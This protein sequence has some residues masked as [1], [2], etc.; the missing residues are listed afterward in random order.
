MSETSASDLLRLNI[1]AA[2]PKGWYPTE[3]ERDRSAGAG[4]AQPT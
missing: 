4:S 2:S 3:E 1:L